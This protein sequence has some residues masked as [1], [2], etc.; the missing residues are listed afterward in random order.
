[1]IIN[2]AERKFFLSIGALSDIADLC[3]NGDIARIGEIFEGQGMMRNIIKVAVALNRGHE[4]AFGDYG[5]LTVADVRG[6]PYSKITELQEEVAKAIAEGQ[7]V[8]VETEVKK[9]IK[10]KES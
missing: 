9:N 6:L 10:A 5:G 8:S 2:G 4:E 1:M 3:P 7:E